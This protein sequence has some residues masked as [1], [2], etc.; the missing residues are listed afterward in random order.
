MTWLTVTKYLSRKWPRIC[1]VCRNYNPVPSSFILIYDFSPGFVIRVTT[2]ATPGAGTAH[3]PEHP[4]CSGVRVARFLMFYV[5]SCR[6]LSV[7]GFWITILY[8]QMFF[9]CNLNFIKTSP[10]KIPYP[11]MS[12]KISVIFASF[13]LHKKNMLLW[14]YFD[15]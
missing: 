2:G 12:R 5:I 10:V 15:K 11:V 1:S 3:T 9:L 13:L 7:L 6:S 14:I 8:L 4:V